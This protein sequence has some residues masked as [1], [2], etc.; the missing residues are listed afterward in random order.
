MQKRVY[1]KIVSLILVL[2]TLVTT[3][4]LTVFANEIGDTVSSAEPEIYIKDIKLVQAKTKEEARLELEAKGYAFLDSNLNEGTGADGIWMGYLE[5]TDPAEAIYDLKVMN[6]KGGFTVTSAQ[7]AL[8]EQETAFTQMAT[9]LNYLV[10]EFVEAYEA[11]DAAAL[12][13]YKALNFFRM[14]SGETELDE[15]NGLGYQIVSGAVSLSELTEILMLCDSDIVDSIVKIL[16]SGIQL[17]NEN[18]MDQLSK[19]GPYDSDKVYGDDEAEIKR[20]AEQLLVVLKFYAKAYNAMDASGLLPDD[21]DEN[22]EPIY[23]KD[24]KGENLPAEEAE[25]K[26]I[27]ESRYKLYKVVFDELAKYKYG[28]AETLKDFFLSMAKESNARKLYP[29]VS[30]LT[31]GEFAALSYGCF[32]EIACGVTAKAEDFDN[33][34]EVYEDLTKEVKSVYL[35]HGVDKALLEDGSVIG[36][37]DAASRH[38]ATTGELEFFENET[39]GEN[40]WE[41]GKQ[42]AKCIGALGMAVMGIA[43]ITFGATMLISGISTTVATSV[44]SGMLAGVMKFCT[45]ISGGYAFL[46]VAVAVLL[47]I[48][49]AYG[50]MAYHDAEDDE[51]DWE[52]YPIPEYLY[53][54]KEIDLRQ[55]S[56]NDGIATETLRK[57]VFVFYE[58]LTDLDGHTIDLNAYSDDATQWLSLY[59][60][61]DRQGDNAKPIKSRDL[62]VKMGNGETPEGYEALTS[63]SQVVPYDLNRWDKEDEVN[64]IYLFYKQD[65]GVVVESNVTHYIYDVYLQ[66]GESDAHCIDLLLAAGYT[67][68][69]VNL[70]PNVTD[71]DIVGADKIYT[72]LGYKTT[73]NENSAI[74]DLRFEYGP[75]QGEVKLG[76]STYAECGSNGYVTLYATKYKS[77]GTPIL[78]GGIKHLTSRNDAPEGYEPVNLFSGGPATNVDVGSKGVYYKGESYLYFLPKTTFTSGQ[79]YLSGVAYVSYLFDA[80]EE[81]MMG[82]DDDEYVVKY[83]KQYTDWKYEGEYMEMYIASGERWVPAYDDE[84]SAMAL[85]KFINHKAGYDYIHGIDNQ[86]VPYYDRDDDC[87]WDVVM[88]SKTYNPYRAIYDLKGTS[89]DGSQPK[90]VFESV[91]YT[92]WAIARWDEH[93]LINPDLL[94]LDHCYLTFNTCPGATEVD[95][96]SRLYVTGNPSSS[97]EYD[98]TEKRMKELQPIALSDFQCVLLESDGGTNKTSLQP[99]TD[100]FTDSKEAIVFCNEKTKKEFGFYFANNSKERPY[101]SAV[102][103]VDKLTLIRNFGGY[104]SGIE[105]SQITDSMMLSQLASQGATNFSGTHIEFYHANDVHEGAGINALKFG[106][107]R[108]AEPSAALRDMFFYF[109]GFSGDAPPKELYRGNVTYKLICEIPYSLT[110]YEEAPK[111]GVYL[112]G[113]TDSRAGNRIVDF[114]VTESPFLW[115][116]ETVRT[117][118]GGS[119]ATEMRHYANTY[120]ENHIFKYVRD[121]FWRIGAFF[122]RDDFQNNENENKMFYF[123]VKREGDSLKQQKPYI[124]E[125][126]VAAGATED[127]ALEQLFHMGAEYYVNM[128]LNSG[129]TIQ[130]SKIFMGYSYTADPDDS[131]K[132][133]V[134]YHEKNPPATL[135]DGSGCNYYLVSDV[136]LNKYALGDYIYLY[137]TKE[138]VHNSDPIVSLN[139]D[140]KVGVGMG[141]M[142]WIDGSNMPVKANCTKRWG[143]DSYSD[144]NRWA[145]GD[146]V[147]LMYNTM[148]TDLVGSYTE[149]EYGYD[150][151]Y[152]RNPVTDMSAEGKYIGALY[153]MDKN[154][155]RQE[156]LAS[157]VAADACTCDKITDEEVFDRL[158]SMGATTVIETP[159]QIGGSVYKNNNNKVFIGYSRT[160]DS[161]KAIK[162][163]AVKAEI[164][165]LKE[166][167]ESIKIDRTY[168]LVAEA[169]V[170]VK[171]LP[172]AINLIGIQDGQDTPMPRMYLYYSNEGTADPIREICIDTDP[173][174]NGWNTARSDGKLDPFA[175][176][177]AQASKQYE[178]AEKEWKHFN[179]SYTNADELWIY[180]KHLMNM[181]EEIMDAFDPEDAEAKPFYIHVKRH[182]AKTLEEVK[183][184]IGQVFIAAGDSRHDALSALMAF[185]PDGF[186]DMDLN[187]DAGGDYVYLGYKRVAKAKDAIT[188]IVVFQGKNPAT[189]RRVKIGET[190]VKYTLAAN[191]DLNKDAGG[192][193]LYLYTTDST[194]TGNPIKNLEFSNTYYQAPSVKCGI[195]WLTVMRAEGDKITNEWMD[196]SKGAGGDYLYMHMQRET[197]AGHNGEDT[198]EFKE[199]LPTCG[200]D[201]YYTKYLLCKDCKVTYEETT[202]KPAT[203]DHSDSEGDGDHKCDECGKKNLTSHVRTDAK[204]EKYKEATKD[205]DG[206]YS[207]VYYCVECSRKLSETKVT[208]PAG[209]P[210]PQPIFGASVLGDGSVIAICLFAAVAILAATIICIVRK[211][212][213]NEQ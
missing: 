189:S 3:L 110:A 98:G 48:I 141:Y 159:I 103:A 67:P 58:A 47:T 172:R 188:D 28:S 164:T 134:A 129:T 184:Y 14:V 80:I 20:R 4:P 124:G 29:L 210:A 208:I 118:D 70:T 162:N 112:Y 133:L 132:G 203:G 55:T 168:K 36:F 202:V 173:I 155:I 169:A 83:L 8:K 69:N 201:G 42:V 18:W 73:T 82:S 137:A 195:E 16:T 45:M 192:K 161:K 46:F 105:Y 190:S 60:T 121:L 165:S 95:L 64:G 100:V 197:T 175:D 138:T 13:A 206:S 74:R 91:G 38:M 120:E 179:G 143:T 193:W 11:A 78:A 181:F 182:D 111:M 171:E 10:K 23:S 109:N 144:L 87:V 76:S 117:M 151:V 116:Y 50:V 170:D 163:I 63:F 31:D 92:S 209:T 187:K 160:N 30:V 158:R 34:D 140:K 68:L 102:T 191:V 136:D 88:Y 106:Y 49:I 25:I 56:A 154:T 44:E 130:K 72:Y 153:V 212:G 1:C 2:A 66:V 33:Y 166:P 9:D 57:P 41:T 150:K 65:K 51:I 200:A 131:I 40:A 128:D 32:I 113:T 126:Y 157:G 35:Y 213:D 77:A 145:G 84:A 176:I 71:D 12:K 17:R 52:N 39:D 86:F 107:T 211:K 89:A 94:H 156:K 167:P 24:N 135:T 194:K 127:S 22:G 21:F 147:Y 81:P 198:G 114:Q 101:V 93:Y 97:N 183:P 178:L 205:T 5:T 174:K 122:G 75:S 146:Y 149:K 142:N 148:N 139:A 7:E 90:L 99:V 115:G 54:V 119:L 123:H 108:S 53:D 43:K 199:K 61:Y 196:F 96:G 37:T 85:Y 6:T 15:E 59:A 104:E 186:I 26:K 79:A 19:K 204:T 180:T 125:I 207:I 27:D 185:E 152:T 62:L 177:Y